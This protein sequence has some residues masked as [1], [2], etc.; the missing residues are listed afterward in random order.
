MKHLD[1]L[2]SVL[3]LNT[4]YN[5]LSHLNL[6]Y[7]VVHESYYSIRQQWVFHKKVC[8][9][10][11]AGRY[12][13]VPPGRHNQDLVPVSSLSIH[14]HSSLSGYTCRSTVISDSS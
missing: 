8:K 11:K 4:V 3:F 12:R 10:Y 6:Y 14:K 9:N 1:M 5:R 7:S 13:L 2:V